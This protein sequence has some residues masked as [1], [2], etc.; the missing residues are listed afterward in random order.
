MNH[1]CDLYSFLCSH[2]FYQQQ[3][4]QQQALYH[5]FQQ[6]AQGFNN[7][8]F[9]FGNG[10]APNY[11]GAGNNFAGSAASFGPGGPYQ[12]AAIIPANPVRI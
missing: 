7:G 9:A 5:Q 2:S 4:A 10:Y 8:Q 11:A 1:C 6:Q 12:T 3:L